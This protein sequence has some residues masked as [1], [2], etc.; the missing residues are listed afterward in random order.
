M[1]DYRVNEQVSTRVNVNDY[2]KDD[3]LAIAIK[4]KEESEDSGNKG[5]S[6][7]FPDA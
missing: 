3:I 1:S 5:R 7:E 4:G 2:E 6:D